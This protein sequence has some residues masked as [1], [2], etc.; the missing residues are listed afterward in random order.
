MYGILRLWQH[1]EQ[2]EVQMRDS[3]RTYVRSKKLLG[4]LEAEANEAYIQRI[5]WSISRY[6]TYRT[7]ISTPWPRAA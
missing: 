5:S 3:L 7:D 1:H 2:L 4:E 6:K